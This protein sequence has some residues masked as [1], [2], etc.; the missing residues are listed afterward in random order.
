MKINFVARDDV[1]KSQKT[2]SKYKPLLDAVEKLEPGGK[3][4]QVTFKN[5][6]ELN[7]MRNVVY[8]YN[9]ETDS[10]VKSSKHADNNVVYFYKS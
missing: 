2:S 4:L 1:S 5:E 7:S 9:K 3:A 8:T 10:D 6:A